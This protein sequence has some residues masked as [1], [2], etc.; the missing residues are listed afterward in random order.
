MSILMGLTM[1]GLPFALLAL[2]LFWLLLKFL[3]IWVAAI[4]CFI[5]LSATMIIVSYKALAW[6]I[7]QY[8]DEANKTFFPYIQWAQIRKAYKTGKSINIKIY[9]DQKND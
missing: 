1:L 2:L 6:W 3:N 7:K 9:D 8:P 4:I 5:L